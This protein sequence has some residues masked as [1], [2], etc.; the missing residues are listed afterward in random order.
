MSDCGRY[1][2]VSMSR[3]RRVVR[4]NYETGINH[5]LISIPVSVDRVEI[6]IDNNLPIPIVA[7]HNPHHQETYKIWLNNWE[8]FKIALPCFAKGSGI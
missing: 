6:Y 4:F 5:D 1:F 2:A 7:V 8:D 3:L